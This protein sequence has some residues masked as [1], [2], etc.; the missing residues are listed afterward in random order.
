MKT[1]ILSMTG[2]M[3]RRALMVAGLSVSALAIATTSGAM[4][5]DGDEDEDKAVKEKVE[6]KKKRTIKV[7]RSGSAPVVVADG[8]RR[9]VISSKHRNRHVEVIHGDDEYEEAIEE[10]EEAL[11]DVRERLEKVKRKED[12]KALKA[13]EK[14]LETALELLKARR[15]HVMAAAPMHWKMA[16]IESDAL[17]EALKEIEIK[18]GDI[19]R[20]RIEL[21][22]DLA[23]AREELEDAL[24]ELDIEIDLDGEVHALHLE[25]LRDAERSMEGFE[26]RHLEALK[27]AEEELK[28]ERERLEKRLE[29]KKAEAKK[30][31]DKD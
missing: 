20:L 16:E 30:N 25:S 23:E 5:H 3:A 22:G 8:D 19:S 13:A 1:P 11:E 12:K 10:A 27:R 2:K 29:K 18:Q 31:K 28:R 9:I 17:R 14:G 15:G 21:K 26:E 6:K 7:V 4:T 24:G